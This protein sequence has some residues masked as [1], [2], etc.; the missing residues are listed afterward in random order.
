M[1]PSGASN[2]AGGRR[3]D[4]A[5]RKRAQLLST[6]AAL[7]ARQGYHRTSIRDVA[8]ETG[9]SL[10][11]MYHYF[12][13]KE[14]LLFQIQHQ[15]FASLLEEQEEVVAAEAAPEEKL[16]AI[17]QNHLSFFTRH[18]NELKVCTFEL[19]S[20]TGETYR[21]VERI[22]RRYF[23]LTTSVVAELLGKKDDAE[24]VRHLTL[25]IFGMLNWIFMWFEPGRDA[26]VDKV[27]EEMYQLVM[28]GLAMHGL[29]LPDIKEEPTP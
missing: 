2:G 22:R 14:E 28:N 19:Q 25:F 11:G 6:A 20:L 16:R 23:G 18:A 5:E 3:Q 21:Q 12:S 9:F 27:G 15:A 10:A 4:Q 17:L 7:M 1:S 24:R 8:R 26:P 13:S 29:P